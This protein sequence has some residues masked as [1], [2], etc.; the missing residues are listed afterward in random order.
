M[1]CSSLVAWLS[2]AEDGKMR[3]LQKELDSERPVQKDCH[4]FGE[5]IPL[6]RLFDEEG[7]PSE[8]FETI[9]KRWNTVVGGVGK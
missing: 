2:E 6:E 3:N 1:N 5:F 9:K 8:E 4:C 7:R